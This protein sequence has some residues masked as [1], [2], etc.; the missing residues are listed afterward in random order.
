MTEPIRLLVPNP[1]ALT[2]EG[3]NTWVLPGTNGTPAV[4]IDPGPD[5]FAHLSRVRAACPDGIEE[6][7]IT[8]GHL[9]HVG[10]ASR[11]A[12]W[13]GCSIRALDPQISMADPLRD[14]ERG[15]V[16][17]MAV[18]CA[19]LPGHSSDSIGFIVSAPSGNMMFCGDTILGRGT[20]QIV[21][22]DGNLA[23]YLATLDKMARL[24]EQYSITRLMPG[25]GPIVHDPAERIARYRTHRLERLDEIRRAYAAGHTSVAAIVDHV[26]GDLV[27]DTQRAAELTVRAQLEYLELSAN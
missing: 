25:H 13:T 19:T 12:E 2:L 27:G 14:G 24:V 8:H 15:E 9:D 20:T 17:G 23:Q 5:D 7:W 3:T 10:G 11:L 6:I 22:P 1:S 16:G 18:V 21:W 26:Y 4:V